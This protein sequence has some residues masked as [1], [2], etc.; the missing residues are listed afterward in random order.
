[1]R[2]LAP[3]LP[4]DEGLGLVDDPE[5]VA[6]GEHQVYLEPDCG[7][8]RLG[9]AVTDWCRTR[10]PVCSSASPLI[11]RFRLVSPAGVRPLSGLLLAV[12]RECENSCIK[13]S[14]GI[15]SLKAKAVASVDL[16]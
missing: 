10:P 7:G 4:D 13:G 5:K 11:D 12:N 1:M 3:D 2:T 6:E 8:E 14:E 15:A 16:E 9:A